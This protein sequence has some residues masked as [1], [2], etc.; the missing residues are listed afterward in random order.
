ML[1]VQEDMLFVGGKDLSLFQ[2]EA[3]G[4]NDTESPKILVLVRVVP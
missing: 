1:V 4:A 2:L 3:I